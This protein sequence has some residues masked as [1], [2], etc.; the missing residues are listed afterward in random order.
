MAKP[1]TQDE[2]IAAAFVKGTLPEED[3]RAPE[4]L[5]GV[6]PEEVEIA[7]DVVSGVAAVPVA[8]SAPVIPN[9]QIH[10]VRELPDGTKVDALGHIFT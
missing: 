2:A 5:P 10:V 1:K 9:D 7:S 8:E 6:V 4:T 3:R